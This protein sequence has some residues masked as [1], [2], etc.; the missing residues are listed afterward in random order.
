MIMKRYVLLAGV[1][2]AGKTTLYQTN[3]HLSDMP[4]IN[5]DEMV[6]DIGTWRNSRDIF[7]AGKK[8]IREIDRCLNEN[9]SFNQETTLCGKSITRYIKRAKEAGYTIEI[10]YVGVDS[11]QIAI[12]RVNQR[13]KDGGHGVPEKDIVKRY[14]ESLKRLRELLPLCDKLDL[15][16]NS[17]EF[18]LIASYQYNSWTIISNTIPEWASGIINS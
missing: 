15:Y 17:K 7:E 3:L 10:Y 6:R 14:D 4:R 2:G 13:I 8:A 12:D 18:K 5:I 9:I 1:N 11:Y 16:D